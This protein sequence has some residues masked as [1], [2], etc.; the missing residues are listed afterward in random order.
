MQLTVRAFGSPRRCDVH[1]VS[2][3]SAILLL[4]PTIMDMTTASGNH[5]LTTSSIDTFGVET[6]K[7]TRASFQDGRGLSAAGNGGSGVAFCFF[8]ASLL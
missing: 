4:A 3:L 5:R 1:S 8:A 7:Y 2:P 6:N